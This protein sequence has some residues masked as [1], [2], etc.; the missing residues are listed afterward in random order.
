MKPTLMLAS[1]HQ[2]EKN[3]YVHTTPEKIFFNNYYDNQAFTPYLSD[4]LELIGK[5]GWLLQNSR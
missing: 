5:Q 3:L 2:S 1:V 4:T